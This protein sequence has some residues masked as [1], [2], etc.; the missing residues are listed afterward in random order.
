MVTYLVPDD[1]KKII[2]GS[3]DKCLHTGLMLTRY[4]SQEAINRDAM[5]D[6]RYTLERDRWLKQIAAQV[7]VK[8]PELAQLI[9]A[10]YDRW[11]AMT[12]GTLQFAMFNRSRLIVGL[13]A[14]GAL[15]MGIT[16]H[17][18]T[19]LP[20]IPGSALKGL[21][22]TYALLTLA[23]KG[24]IAQDK[25]EQFNADLILGK[26][27]DMPNAEDYRMIFGWG[28]DGKFNLTTSRAGDIIFHDAM[29]YDLSD[30]V[31]G[32]AIFTLDV[33]TPHVPKYYRSNGKDAP[34]D[35]DS[36]NP[37]TF[38]TVNAG[39]IFAFAVGSRPGVTDESRK[40][41]RKWL[42]NGLQELGVGSKTA[43][44]YGIFKKI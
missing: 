2:A 24:G 23:E 19:G 31:D 6:D 12:E 30:A 40:L 37:V 27:D 22:R 14:K 33:M 4:S 1:T 5:A 28:V 7:T 43:A 26:Y 34:T 39:I 44:G 15:E 20:Y 35:A 9:K 13:G 17:H 18:S 25:L 32:G 3:V 21:A 16:L 8:N 38:L 36:P 42:R 29:V 11:V 41:A 10:T